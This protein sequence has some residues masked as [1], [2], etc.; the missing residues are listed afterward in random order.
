MTNKIKVFKEEQIVTAARYYDRKCWVPGADSVVRVV[1]NTRGNHLPG[2]EHV[3]PF[4]E[5][6]KKGLFD[7]CRGTMTF[8]VYNDKNEPMHWV[9]GLNTYGILFDFEY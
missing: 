3:L 2:H 4:S 8:S 1:R 9:V 6:V 7:D 5:A